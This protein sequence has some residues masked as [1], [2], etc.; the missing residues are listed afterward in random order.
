MTDIYI[1]FDVCLLYWYKDFIDLHYN[2]QNFSLLFANINI[3]ICI[4][5]HIFPPQE[6]AQYSYHFIQ[7]EP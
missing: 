6:W 1:L 7:Y 3:S 2:H 5:L 4:K